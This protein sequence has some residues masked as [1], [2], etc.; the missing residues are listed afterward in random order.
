MKM[1]YVLKGSH[2]NPCTR[3]NKKTLQQQKVPAGTSGFCLDFIDT[4]VGKCNGAQARRGWRGRG[5]P[6]III[7]KEIIRFNNNNNNHLHPRAT[8][9]P[10][11]RGSSRWAPHPPIRGGSSS[12]QEPPAPPKPSYPALC[13]EDTTSWNHGRPMSEGLMKLKAVMLM[14]AWLILAVHSTF[15][16]NPCTIIRTLAAMMTVM[17]MRTWLVL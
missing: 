17:M 15:D 14:L 9:L 12:S 16:E 4:F 2:E 1:H 10:P 6:T 11:D 7:I 5:E 13:R 8:P 3:S